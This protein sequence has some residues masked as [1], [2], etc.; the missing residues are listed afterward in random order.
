MFRTRAFWAVLSVV[1]GLLQVWDSGA[2]GAGLMVGALALSGITV[3]AA[4]IGISANHAFRL[5]A[6]VAGFALL[7]AA[8][9]MAP[10]SL[11]TL[12]LALFVPAVYLLVAFRWFEPEPARN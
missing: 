5:T 9:V 3:V 8:R 2:F 11:N 1:V 6:L 12:H 7:T 10:S 4:A